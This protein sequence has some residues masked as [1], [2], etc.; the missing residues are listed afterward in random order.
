MSAELLRTALAHHAAGR[1]PEAE[2]LYRR[3]LTNDPRNVDAAAFRTRGLASENYVTFVPW[4]SKARFQGLLA[5]ATVFLDTIG[6]S[7][8]NTALHA[9][10]CGLP[11]VAWQGGFLRGRLASGIL[12]RMGMRELVAASRQQYVDLAVRL[13]SDADY[14]AAIS[15]Q[16]AE[17]RAVLFED[18]APVR[19]LERFL[20]DATSQVR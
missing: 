15:R 13:A 5:R 17:R 12:E 6:F 10:V 7:G 8:F 19:A 3:M 9:V 2:S 1:L 4:L 18:L 11:I 16:F 20:V 14:R